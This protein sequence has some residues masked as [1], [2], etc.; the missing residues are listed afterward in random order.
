MAATLT[1]TDKGKRAAAS[2]FG[3]SSPLLKFLANNGPST[4]A[5]ISDG[6]RA[7]PGRVRLVA[8]GLLRKGYLSVERD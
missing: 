6:L 3:S 7:G 1:L 5:D 8:K 2:S 4:V